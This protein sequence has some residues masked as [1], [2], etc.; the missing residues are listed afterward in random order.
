MDPANSLPYIEIDPKAFLEACRVASSMSPIRLTANWLTGHTPN[1][2]NPRIAGRESGFPWRD[3]STIRLTRCAQFHALTCYRWLPS[4]QASN[5]GAGQP[6]SSF[7]GC[8]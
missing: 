8:H 1:S 4:S 3:C 5:N 2:K 7:S 6:L